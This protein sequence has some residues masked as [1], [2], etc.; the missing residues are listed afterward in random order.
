M[1]RDLDGFASSFL[2]SFNAQKALL[3]GMIQSGVQEYIDKYSKKP[4][5]LAWKMSGSGGGGYLVLVCH[6]RADFPS[7]AIDL[8]IRRE[9][10]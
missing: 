5:V 9:K 1:Q 10:F 4:G 8:H 3:P 7:G 2:A 6:S